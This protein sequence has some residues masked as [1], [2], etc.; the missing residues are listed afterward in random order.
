MSPLRIRLSYANAVSTLCLF[1]VLGGGAYAASRLPAKSVGPRQLRNGAVTSSKVKDGSL[2]ARDLA[3]GL[4]AMGQPGAKG[5]P[6]PPGPPGPPGE[7]GKPGAPGSARAYAYVNAG[8][9]P[10]LDPARSHGFASVSEPQ[11]GIYCLAPE[12]GISLGSTAPLVTA[13]FNSGLLEPE[14][15]LPSRSYSCAS[16]QLQVLT[17]VPGGP[18]TMTDAID[19]T[20]ALP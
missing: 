2:Q 18:I 19:F 16:D 11:T 8:S 6:G 14:F 10:S 17:Y 5:D 3:Q 20:V 7:A 1:L 13:V 12:A 15:A 4:A 9:S